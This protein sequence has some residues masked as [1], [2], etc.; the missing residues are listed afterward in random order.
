MERCGVWNIMVA[1]WPAFPES[2]QERRPSFHG[3]P[4]TTSCPDRMDGGR[5]GESGQSHDLKP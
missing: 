4:A 1:H 5:V 2:L 3:K